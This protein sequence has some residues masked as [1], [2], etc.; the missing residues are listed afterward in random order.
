MEGKSRQM[1][2]HRG[3]KIAVSGKLYAKPSI[4]SNCG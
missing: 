1:A 4:I 2:A 3:R